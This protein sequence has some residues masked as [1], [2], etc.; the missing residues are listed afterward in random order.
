MAFVQFGNGAHQCTGQHYALAIMRTWMS[1]LIR[2]YRLSLADPFLP[3]PVWPAVF[4]TA[5]PAGPTLVQLN[6]TAKL[7][8]DLLCENEEE[9]RKMMPLSRGE[10]TGVGAREKKSSSN[11]RTC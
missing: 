7:T 3:A 11:S 9:E 5:Y 8:L 6:P 10:G 4:G 2:N 1:V